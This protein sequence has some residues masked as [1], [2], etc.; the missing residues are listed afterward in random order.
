MIKLNGIDNRGY[1]YIYKTT[2]IFIMSL[3][4]IMIGIKHFKDPNFFIHIV[5]DYLSWKYEVVYISGLIEVILGVLLIFKK[6]RKL[7]SYG[8][9]L[10]LVAVFPANIYLYESEIAQQ[11]LNISK[12]QALIRMPFQIPLILIAFWHSKE[13]YSNNI[14]IISA[15]LFVPTIIYFSTL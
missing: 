14:S 9:I 13:Q 8:L 15:I 12:N 3:L 6:S 1:Y 5:P 11:S 4:Y 10:L 7:A 2:T